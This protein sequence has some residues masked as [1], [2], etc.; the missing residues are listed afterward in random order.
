MCCIALIQAQSGVYHLPKLLAAGV[1][2]FRVEL[3]DEPASSVVPLLEGYA[4]VL[5]GKRSARSLWEEL[6]D[7]GGGSLDVRAER[8]WEVLRP[9]ARRS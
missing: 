3:V 2:C 8:Q 9:T 4:A 7:V 6:G 1:G 5:A